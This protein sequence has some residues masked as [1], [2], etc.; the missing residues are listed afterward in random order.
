MSS[1]Q[2]PRVVAWHQRSP[3]V[4]RYLES[5]FIDKFFNEGELRLSSF[6]KFK[7]HPDEQRGDSHEGKAILVTGGNNVTAYAIAEFGGNALVMSASEIH[8]KELYDV[9]CVD[10]CFAVENPPMFGL[11]ICR[12]ISNCIAGMQGPCNYYDRRVLEKD[13]PTLRLEDF[14]ISSNGSVAEPKAVGQAEMNRIAGPALQSVFGDDAIFLKTREYA[15]QREHRLVW[16]TE[17]N[18]P[19]TL[20]I[21]CPDAVQY[22][23]RLVYPD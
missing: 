20:I 13:S 23:K 15:H 18:V 10:G 7:Q 11:A 17:N 22:C 3:V 6:K 1:K 19:E 14:G 9:F 16:F 12:A 21:S 5:Q 2:I 4:Y 8:Q